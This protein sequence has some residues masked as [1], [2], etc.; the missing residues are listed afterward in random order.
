MFHS[1]GDQVV[2]RIRSRV[3][4]LSDWYTL[5]ILT[6]RTLGHQGMRPSTAYCFHGP[7]APR[8]TSAIEVL[9]FMIRWPPDWMTKTQLRLA[10]SHQ[11]INTVE[12]LLHV[13][14]FNLPQTEGV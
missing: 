10:V 4:I 1:T 14:D 3:G 6:S 7:Y 9:R 11:I 5:F 12:T 13:V 8:R 2:E